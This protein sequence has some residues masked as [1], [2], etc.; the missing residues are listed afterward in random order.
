MPSSPAS[1]RLFSRIVTLAAGLLVALAGSVVASGGGGGVPHPETLLPPPPPWDG[2]S[3]ALITD[4]D[5]PWR[6][7]AEASDFART[8]SYDDTVA[9]LRRLVDAA[10][11][12]HLLPFGESGAG[13]TLWLV[14]AARGLETPTPA[15]LA[16]LDRPVVLAQAGI[17]AGEI[18][19][20][21]AGLMLL[22]DLG[23]GR[24]GGDL[25]ARAS[26]L[27]VPVLN[28]D[29]H[30]RIS[31]YGRV[32]QRGPERM[33]WRTN[34]RNLNLN[35][36]Y[37]KADAPEMRAVLDL[38]SAWQPDLYLDLHVTDGVDYQYDITW[39]HG[40]RHMAS[41]A[42]AAFF[43]DVLTPAVAAHLSDRGHVPGPLVF[44]FD[45]GDLTQ[46]IYGWTA[47]PRYSDGYGAARHLPTILVENHSLKP[48]DQRVLGTYHFLVGVLDAVVDHADALR[49]A[50]ARDRASR[51]D[52][53]TLAWR[54][55]EPP[56]PEWIDFRGVRV[57][58]APSALTGGT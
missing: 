37:A 34:A 13:R 11:D 55:P 35:R 51:P 32:N 19:G 42:I 8:P 50:T 31:P 41:P 14:V 29:G 7:V 1:R 26:L 38:I 17:H 21:D 57:E 54:M 16:R 5:D 6:T 9:Y 4:A 2:A 36:D 25:L 39:G 44:A 46:G 45:R 58:T 12:L 10:P 28:P 52:P 22:R 27:F 30:E 47:T 18:D 56:A 24:R 20:K 33:G 53:V 49:A 15:A 48:Y 3:R 23:L 43:E 40:G